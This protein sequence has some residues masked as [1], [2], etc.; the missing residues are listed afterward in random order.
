[1]GEISA[2]ALSEQDVSLSYRMARA[3]RGICPVKRVKII[4]VRAGGIS[5]TPSGKIRLKATREAFR[6]NSLPLLEE[7]LFTADSLETVD[8]LERPPVIL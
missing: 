7:R 3:L 2:A 8:V 4:L 6:E 5:R 1:M